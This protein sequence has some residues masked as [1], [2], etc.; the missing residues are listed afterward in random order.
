MTRFSAATRIAIGITCLTLSLLLAAQGL[1][2]IP[3][4][5]DATLKGRKELCESLAIHCSVAAH[6]NELGELTTTTRAVAERNP[7]ILSL[8]LRRAD[9]KVLLSSGDHDATW[10]GAEKTRS[11]PTHVRVPIFQ[12]DANW[13]TLEVVFKPLVGTG[14]MKWVKDPVLGLIGFVA[15]A[16]FCGYTFYL[17]RMLR[18]LDPSAVIPDRVKTMLNTLA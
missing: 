5:S 2:V 10:R 12:D 16:G 9:G 17:K 8:A 1:G 7:D 4:P 15:V 3:S 13:G 18:H 11:T 6:R 14:V